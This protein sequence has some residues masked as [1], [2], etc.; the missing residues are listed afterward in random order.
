WK[1]CCLVLTVEKIDQERL[2][3]IRLFFLPV[4]VNCV[5]DAERVKETRISR[6]AAKRRVCTK[7]EAGK[8]LSPTC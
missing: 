5:K 1:W 3:S 8:E 6:L 2:R 4:V 7:V